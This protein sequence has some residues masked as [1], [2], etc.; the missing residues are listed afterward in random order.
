MR[1]AAAIEDAPTPLLAGAPPTDH[2]AVASF[3]FLFLFSGLAVACFVIR[4]YT[5][6]CI[7][8]GIGLLCSSSI[9][10]ASR[11]HVPTSVVDEGGA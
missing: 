10:V 5:A 4:E 7:V 9:Y 3:V 1:E 8:V 6:T 2:G 11:R